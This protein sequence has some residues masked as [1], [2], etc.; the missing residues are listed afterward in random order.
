MY[1]SLNKALDRGRLREYKP[2]LANARGSDFRMTQRMPAA[3][4]ALK[5]LLNISVT[6]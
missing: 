5:N 6:G 4:P 3:I 1:R 2:P